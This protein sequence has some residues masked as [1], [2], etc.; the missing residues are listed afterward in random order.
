MKE[1]FFLFF[2]LLKEEE[3]EEERPYCWER[4]LKSMTLCHNIS[5]QFY[6]TILLLHC[7]LHNI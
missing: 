1:T 2:F 4:T 6:F 3:E 5:F 7:A